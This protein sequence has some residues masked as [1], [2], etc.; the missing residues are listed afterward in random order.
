LSL[1][2]E[3]LMRSSSVSAKKVCLRIRPAGPLAAA[4]VGVFALA[5]EGSERLTRAEAVAEALA[6]NP[7]IEAARAQVEQARAR[8]SEA[9]ALPDA[10]FVGV[11]AKA[12]VEVVGQLA[13]ASVP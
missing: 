8:V 1:R 4:L 13:A 6:R 11:N 5:A 3:W 7:A 9:K 2:E 10:S 12:T